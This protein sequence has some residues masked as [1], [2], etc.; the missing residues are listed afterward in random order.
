MNIEKKKLLPFILTAAVIIADQITKFLVEFYIPLDYAGGKLGIGPSFFGD[1]LRFI[2]VYNTGVAFSLGDSLPLALRRLSFGLIPLIVMILVIV[3]YFRNKD[4]T[5]FQRWAIC[6][7]L[8]GGFG[9]LIDRFFRPRG[10]VDFIDVKFYGIFGL[11]R[12]P[13]FNI[14]D[15]AVV[16]CGIMLIVSFVILI[17]KEAKENK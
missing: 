11:E 7:I 8:G 9:N 1:F 5:T 3:V 13:T 15:A 4:F 16:V 2:R 10:V 6:G 17:I 14:A 12:W